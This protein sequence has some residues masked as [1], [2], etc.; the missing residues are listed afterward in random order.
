[1]SEL[2]NDEVRSQVGN[3][4]VSLDF[5]VENGEQRCF[6]DVSITQRGREYTGSLERLRHDGTLEDVD[7]YPA[8][9]TDSYL[10]V[11]DSLIEEIEEWAVANGY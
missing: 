3:A 7:W 5:F 8:L 4:I 10:D 6:C 1:M 11:D 9:V 2:R